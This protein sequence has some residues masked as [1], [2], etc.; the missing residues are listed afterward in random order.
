[1]PTRVRLADLTDRYGFCDPAGSKQRVKRLR[2]RSA[3]IVIAVDSAGRI[4]VLYAYAGRLPTDRLV[5]KIIDVARDFQPRVFGIEANAMQ[6]LFADI[7]VRDSSY[8]NVKVPI[9][10]VYQP[11]HVEKDYRIRTAIQPVLG[12]GRLFVRHDQHEL[13]SEISSF[14]MSPTV[15]LVDA[16]ASAI[17]LAPQRAVKAQRE[18]ESKALAEYLKRSGA[19]Q[20]YIEKRLRDIDGE[21]H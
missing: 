2:A 5:E 1:M 20:R 17:T 8:R 19:D 7:V 14:P 3:I 16:L 10:P 9:S 18:R 12:D 11:S 6:A 15:D 13:I 21:Q 4:Y